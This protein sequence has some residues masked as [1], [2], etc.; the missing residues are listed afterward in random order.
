VGERLV[1]AVG[2]QH[3]VGQPGEGVEVGLKLE[4]VLLLDLAGHVHRGAHR[5]G[6]RTMDVGERLGMDAQPAH[7]VVITA[8]LQPYRPGIRVAGQHPVK[9]KT[10]AIAGQAF[11]R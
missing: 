11:G 9:R 10:F 5:S 4:A 1:E 3:P 6:H 2:E 8:H 7:P